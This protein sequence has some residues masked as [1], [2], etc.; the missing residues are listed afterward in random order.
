MQEA[1]SQETSSHQGTIHDP[2]TGARGAWAHLDGLAGERADLGALIN[3][4]R[5]PS[6]HGMRVEW[7][8]WQPA[9]VTQGQ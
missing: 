1:G 7:Q 6:I 9:E 2:N 5:W 4:V 3:Q 8:N